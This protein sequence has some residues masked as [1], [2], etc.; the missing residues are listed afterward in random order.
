MVERRKL[1]WLSLPRACID[2]QNTL[3]V[4]T[5]PITRVSRYHQVGFT[6]EELAETRMH[7][8]HRVDRG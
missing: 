6:S 8:L 5:A 7:E 2:V 1:G 3:A 4:T